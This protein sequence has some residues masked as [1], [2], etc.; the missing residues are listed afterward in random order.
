M[1][2]QQQLQ[3]QADRLTTELDNLNIFPQTLH[4]YA[5]YLRDYVEPEQKVDWSLE[6][7]AAVQQA[8]IDKLT[9]QG[10]EIDQILF[11]LQ[12]PQAD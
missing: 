5:C 10:R 3:Q 7:L 6:Q 8:Y 2:L 11:N 1:S 4:W 12:R 9:L